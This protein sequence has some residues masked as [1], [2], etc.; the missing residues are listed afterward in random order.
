MATWLEAPG[1][2]RLYC[3]H[4]AVHGQERIRMLLSREG[5]GGLVQPLVYSS[6][7]SLAKGPAHHP[8]HPSHPSE[9]PT[10]PTPQSCAAGPCSSGGCGGH[11]SQ[12]RD[13]S[14]RE[15]NGARERQWAS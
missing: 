9:A 4:G 10:R 13:R 2:D 14:P 5:G 6:S 1:T 12:G 11:C 7:G 8:S 3:E 15:G